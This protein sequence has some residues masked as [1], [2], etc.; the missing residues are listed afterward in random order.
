MQ[1]NHIDT[2]RA[3]TFPQKRHWKTGALK[4]KVYT[5]NLVQLNSENEA[6]G[7]D[8]VFKERKHKVESW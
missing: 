1:A 5:L 6:V 4:Q 8:L 2:Q 3:H 7:R